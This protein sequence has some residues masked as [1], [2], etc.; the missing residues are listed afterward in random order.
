M[1][2]HPWGTD[3]ILLVLLN[4]K[5][6]NTQPSDRQQI[7]FEQRSATLHTITLMFNEKTLCPLAFTPH[8]T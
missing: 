5:H 1:I 8:C 2:S 4:Y 7:V 6:N 3:A